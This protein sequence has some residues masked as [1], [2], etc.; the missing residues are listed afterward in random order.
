MESLLG[1]GPVDILEAYPR[2]NTNQPIFTPDPAETL[3]IGDSI[4]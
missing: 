2:Q 1:L 4:T 3:P